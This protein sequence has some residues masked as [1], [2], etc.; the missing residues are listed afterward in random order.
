MHKNKN[1]FKNFNL[2][3]IQKFFENHCIVV[4]VVGFGLIL[5]SSLLMGNFEVFPFVILYFLGIAFSLLGIL[6]VII[7]KLATNPWKTFYILT[8]VLV[9]LLGFPIISNQLDPKDIQTILNTYITIDVAVLSVIFAV[10]AIRPEMVKVLGKET[11][12]FKGFI[13]LVTFMLLFSTI[14][15]C[16][17]FLKIGQNSIACIGIMD[18][19]FST[20]NFIFWGITLLTAIMIANLMYYTSVFVNAI[21]SDSNAIENDI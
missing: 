12:H 2:G 1:L 4:T 19:N 15:Y 3:T 5:I 20:F 21:T 17:S 11:E 9:I 18:S 10:M 8:I 7:K 14:F 6:L 13:L 16:F